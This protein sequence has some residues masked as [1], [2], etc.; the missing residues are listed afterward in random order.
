MSS[1]LEL[2]ESVLIVFLVLYSIVNQEQRHKRVCCPHR[3][4]VVSREVIKQNL[5]KTMLQI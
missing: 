2:S 1:H 5:L 4:K 3:L